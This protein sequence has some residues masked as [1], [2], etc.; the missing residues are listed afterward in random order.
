MTEIPNKCQY[1]EYVTQ[2]TKM[3]E[4]LDYLV[5]YKWYC[6]ILRK[7]VKQDGLCSDFKLSED[8]RMTEKRLFSDETH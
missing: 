7:F 8:F 6:K 5:S 1:C 2:H 3:H 4:D